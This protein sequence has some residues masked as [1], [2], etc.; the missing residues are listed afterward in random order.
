M[1][2]RLILASASPR[3]ADLLRSAGVDFDILPADIAEEPHA[4]EAP[5]DFVLRL[6]GDKARA[7]ATG[8]GRDDE[9]PV[10]GADT[11]VVIDNQILG[12][13]R[14]RAAATAMIRRLQGRVHE[15]ITA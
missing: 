14:D 13:P 15:V 3:R 8:Q 7:I 2:K 4:E 5:R 1:G 9:R 10:L 6:A 12:K 11:I